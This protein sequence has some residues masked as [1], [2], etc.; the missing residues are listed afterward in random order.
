M[1]LDAYEDEAERVQERGGKS[2]RRVWP[3][4]HWFAPDALD[5]YAL[6]ILKR[7]H[8]RVNRRVRA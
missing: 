4:V 1:C 7:S 5:A 6:D 3:C 2:D 8:P